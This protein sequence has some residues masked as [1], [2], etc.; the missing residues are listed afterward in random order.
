MHAR[1]L[2]HTPATAIPAAP[3]TPATAPPPKPS[4]PPTTPP[5]LAPAL[6]PATLEK[7]IKQARTLHVSSLCVRQDEATRDT[8]V[9]TYGRSTATPAAPTA[10]ATILPTPCLT[11]CRR[12][13][14]LFVGRSFSSSLEGL[15]SKSGGWLDILRFF[16]A[17]AIYE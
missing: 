1:I 9:V 2:E 16:K 5:F 4:T 10:A 7:T 13:L 8:L 15:L 6:A 12:F 3:T 17:C 14:G 11:P